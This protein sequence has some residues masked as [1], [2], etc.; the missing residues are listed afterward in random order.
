MSRDIHVSAM[1]RN[2]T[3]R[4]PRLRVHESHGLEAAQRFLFSTDSACE[5]VSPFARL[6]ARFSLSDFPDFFAMPWRGDLSDICCPSV[7]GACPVPMFGLY[8]DAAVLSRV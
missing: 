5:V 1:S 6:S 7:L 8:A 4:L 3:P 2:R